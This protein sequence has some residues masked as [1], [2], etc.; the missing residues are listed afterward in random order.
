MT[1]RRPDQLPAS[2]VLP[3][4]FDVAKAEGGNATAR[5]VADRQLRVQQFIRQD[6]HFEAYVMALDIRRRVGF[7]VTQLLSLADGL[8]KKPAWWMKKAK[9]GFSSHRS[10]GDAP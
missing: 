2:A 8:G 3:V 6:H 10:I 1:H 4:F 9:A 7:G 5:D